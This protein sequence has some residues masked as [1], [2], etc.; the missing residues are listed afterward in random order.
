MTLRITRAESRRELSEFIGVPWSIYPGRYPRWVPP[1]R[2]M[3]KEMVDRGH[4]P[5]WKNAERALL[6]ARRNGTP[7]GRIAAIE[8]RRH[9]EIHGD[10]VGFFGF[11]ECRDDPDVAAALFDAAS[12][13]LAGRGLDR[14]RGPVSPSMNHEAGLLV[15]GFQ[16]HPTLMTA[17]NPPYYESLIRGA[18]F[19]PVKDLVAYL[20]DVDGGFRIPARLERILERRSP[21]TG[22]VVRDLDPKEIEAEAESIRPLFNE[23][24]QGNWGFVPMT[25]DEFRFTA[26]SLKPILMSHGAMVAE[27]DGETVGF[28][29]VVAD[30]NRIF[31]RIPSGRLLPFGWARILLGLRR[32][33][34]ARVM[35]LGLHPEHRH[36]ILFPRFVYEMVARWHRLGRG[37]GEASWILEENTAMRAPLESLGLAPYRR[38]RIFERPVAPTEA[39]AASSPA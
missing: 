13:W 15:E 36:G 16:H 12:Q 26:K 21:G 23:A 20:F 28:I 17:W 9:N 1:L 5:F 30:L 27:K 33:R 39:S 35:L 25:P 22:V 4:D 7:V 19:L 18:G 24:W 2:V 8:N 32:I 38:W 31:R 34:H 6:V 10:R 29:A 37:S 3:V 14:M 11:F